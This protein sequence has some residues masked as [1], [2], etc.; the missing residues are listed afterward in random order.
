MHAPIH[1]NDGVPYDESTMRVRQCPR[2]HN[3]DFSE[4]AQYC[5]ICGMDLYNR[6][7][8]MEQDSY[9]NWYENE[10]AHHCNPSNAR[11][12]ETCGRPT[13]FYE[14]KILC[15]YAKFKPEAE[16]G[17]D[18]GD[19]DGGIIPPHLK[20]V[21]AEIAAAPEAEGYIPEQ[22]SAEFVT[23]DDDELPF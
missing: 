10:N 17:G 2:C 20:N 15:D 18:D 21:F 3:S 12:C 11:Y 14:Q 1:Y 5:R 7:D 19:A 16:D 23:V 4:N 8:G 22:D 13:F 6:C 9:G